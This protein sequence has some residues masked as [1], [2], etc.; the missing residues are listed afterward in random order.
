MYEQFFDKVEATEHVF[1]PYARDDRNA[2]FHIFI[3]KGLKFDS[4]ALKQIFKDRIFE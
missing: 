2:Y 3:C 4:E 1:C